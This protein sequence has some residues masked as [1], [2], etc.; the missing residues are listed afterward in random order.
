M[1]R[2]SKPKAARKKSVLNV[3][4]EIVEGILNGASQSDIAKLLGM[5]SGQ[6]NR[7]I[8]NSS[9]VKEALAK[10]RSELSTISQIKRADAIAGIMEAIDLAKLCADPASMIRGWAEIA[11]MLGFYAPE[12][13]KIEITNATGSMIKKY[14]QMSDEELYQL[15]H[16]EIIEG[17]SHRVEH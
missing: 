9:D 13:K 12:T 3:N 16:G 5:D 1:P 7:K 8:K 2:A 14:E 6:M 11:K 4:E 17:E 10:A 15:A